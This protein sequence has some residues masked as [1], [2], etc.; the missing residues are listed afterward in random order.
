MGGIIQTP[1]SDLYMSYSNRVTDVTG[2]Y[3]AGYFRREDTKPFMQE[4]RKEMNELAQI[5]R[6]EKKNPKMANIVKS[7]RANVKLLKT[8]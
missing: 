4:L 3:P 1:V 5:R 8:S 2:G 6:L 7:Q